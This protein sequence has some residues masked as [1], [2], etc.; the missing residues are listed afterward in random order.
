MSEWI[1]VKERLPELEQKVLATS[2]P[3][4]KEI[5]NDNTH[6]AFITS[7]L[8]IYTGLECNYFTYYDYMEWK[9]VTHWMPLPKP[10][11]EL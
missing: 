3:Y 2:E 6:V 9:E 5:Y 1:S 8:D 7:F 4:D 10:P 11:K